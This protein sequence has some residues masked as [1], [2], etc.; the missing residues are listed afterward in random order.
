M[1]TSIR[2]QYVVYSLQT[3]LKLTQNNKSKWV[4][5]LSVWT[6]LG[7]SLHYRDYRTQLYMP[8]L[9]KIGNYWKMA[10]LE[11]PTL[12]VLFSEIRDGLPTVCVE[13]HHI[14]IS[15]PHH[16]NKHP[17]TCCNKI[18]EVSRSFYQVKAIA[19]VHVWWNLCNRGVSNG[20]LRAHL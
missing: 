1:N 15:I 4:E 20:I 6:H 12:R 17:A 11:P 19:L 7:A 3:F 14:S 16:W 8:I 13:V 9:T 10:N 2:S 5:W 18:N